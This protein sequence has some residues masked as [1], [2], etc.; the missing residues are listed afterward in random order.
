MTESDANNFESTL[1][2][3]IFSGFRDGPTVIAGRAAAC[4]VGRTVVASGRCEEREADFQLVI[5]SA[6]AFA[7]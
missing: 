5:Y 3:F 6:G 1:D 4:S 2:F 7:A